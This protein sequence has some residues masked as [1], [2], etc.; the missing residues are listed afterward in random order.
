M[1][2]RKVGEEVTIPVAEQATEPLMGESATERVFVSVGEVSV[3][4]ES[5]R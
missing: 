4:F 5:V 1:P 3:V 2:V